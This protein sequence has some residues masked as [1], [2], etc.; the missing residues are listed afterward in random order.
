ME[1]SMVRRTVVAWLPALLSAAGCFDVH[2][3]DPGPLVIDDFDDGDLL[4]TDRRFDQWRC[5]AFNPSTNQNYGCDHD[6]GD[7]SPHSLVLTATI[8]DALNGTQDHGGAGLY[9][10]TDVPE[11]FSRF[12][13]LVFSDMLE[14]GNPPIP[15]NALLYMEL[16]CSTA[17]ADDGSTPGDLYVNQGASYKNYWQTIRLGLSSFS[18][19]PWQDR[20]LQGG[21]AACLASVDSIH[22]TVDA[23]LPDGQTGRFILHV[24]DIYFQ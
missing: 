20:H 12:H 22:I 16:G 2:S 19:P 13:A 6:L 23:Q 21:P 18:S 10:K 1:R 14:S 3:V 11:D 9:T 24:D 7:N 15:S 8:A 5:L 4:P 17:H